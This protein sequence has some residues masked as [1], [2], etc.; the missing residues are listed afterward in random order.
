MNNDCDYKRVILL[1]RSRYRF[2]DAFRAE[3]QNNIII[4]VVERS[5]G[6][7]RGLFAK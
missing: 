4:V 5:I 6:R 7:R 1:R 3:F 2:L